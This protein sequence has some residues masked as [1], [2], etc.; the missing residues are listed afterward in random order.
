MLSCFNGK[1][2]IWTVLERKAY[3]KQVENSSVQ[4]KRMVSGK[5]LSNK[6]FQLK[7]PKALSEKWLAT[8]LKQPSNSKC[9][10]VDEIQVQNL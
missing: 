4:L 10:S 8:S 7:L 1:R 6:F 3:E 2:I 9:P 5:F